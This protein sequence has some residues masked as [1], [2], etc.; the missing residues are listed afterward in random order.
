MGLLLELLSPVI[1]MYY[2]LLFVADHGGQGLLPHH[3]NWRRLNDEVSKLIGG[4]HYVF[5]FATLFGENHVGDYVWRIMW[6]IFTLLLSWY[7]LGGLW[8]VCLWVNRYLPACFT[9][10]MEADDRWRVALDALSPEDRDHL[11]KE[12]EDA[13]AEEKLEMLHQVEQ[14]L[15]EDITILGVTN[16]PD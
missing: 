9:D 7:M 5:G 1:M 11:E 16:N 13:T 14:I 15:E 3:L 8:R 10:K 2:A 4:W 12:A 6:D